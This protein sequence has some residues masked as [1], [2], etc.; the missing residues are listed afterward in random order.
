MQ[1][2]FSSLF[3]LHAAVIG[4][5]VDTDVLLD[6]KINP[7]GLWGAD[8][9]PPSEEIEYICGVMY[10]NVIKACRRAKKVDMATQYFLE[11]RPLFNTFKAQEPEGETPYLSLPIDPLIY[12]EMMI[13]H[14]DD[15]NPSHALTFS[16]DLLQQCL[17]STDLRLLTKKAQ[18]PIPRLT[19]RKARRSKGGAQIHVPDVPSGLVTVLSSAKAFTHF[20]T[21]PLWDQATDERLLRLVCLAHF[22]LES[23]EE[24][25]NFFNVVAVR[26][27]NPAVLF[28]N[29]AL[30]ACGRIANAE[31]ALFIFDHLI[32]ENSQNPKIVSVS[33][34]S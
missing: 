34:V 2:T 6:I 17:P 8:F 20:A 3:L 32:N 23:W 18:P 26:F 5:V 29:L 27:T 15:G 10:R 19:S 1:S 28:Y 12:C 16:A 22:R 4:A 13:L 31:Q 9:Q 33:S 11:V 24:V 7:N 21:P 30:S 25:V 14:L